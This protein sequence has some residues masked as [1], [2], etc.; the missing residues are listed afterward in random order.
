[1]A[2]TYLTDSAQIQTDL[3]VS[4]AVGDKCALRLALAKLTLVNNWK[5]QAWYDAMLA[6]ASPGTDENYLRAREAESWLC[7]WFAL[8]H[9]NTILEDAGGILTATWTE[10]TGIKTEKRTAGPNTIEYV[11]KEVLSSARCLVM[12]EV[13]VE[14]ADEAAKTGILTVGGISPFSTL[15]L[16]VILNENEA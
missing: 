2:V 15:G 5:D 6:L 16:S 4:A 7:Y 10:S 8:P 1:M 11:R 9:L 3:S 14:Y 12:V 13:E